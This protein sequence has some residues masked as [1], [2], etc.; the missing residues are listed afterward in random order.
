H[1]SPDQLPKKVKQAFEVKKS[2]LPLHIPMYAPGFA[3]NPL[4]IASFNEVYYRSFKDET[5]IVPIHSYFH[6]L[7][8]ISDWNKLYG[9]NGFIQYQVDIPKANEPKEAMRKILTK[10]S[11]EKRSSFL[12]VLKSSGRANDGLLSFMKEG[13]T[14]ALDIPIKDKQLFESIKELDA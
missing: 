9:K 8:A 1:A 11:N 3:L 13:Y 14:L 4:T 2:K 10:L 5:K 6:P 7:D 12:A